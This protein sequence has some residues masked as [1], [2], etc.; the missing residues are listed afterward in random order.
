MYSNISLY[1]LRGLNLD[2]ATIKQIHKSNPG[3][4]WSVDE[5]G[6][7]APLYHGKREKFSLS[8]LIEKLERLEARQSSA[9][10]ETAHTSKYNIINCTLCLFIKRGICF[11]PDGLVHTCTINMPDSQVQLSEDTLTHTKLASHTTDMAVERGSMDVAAV[12][13]TPVSEQQKSCSTPE[14]EAMSTSDG[15]SKEGIEQRPLNRELTRTI[16]VQTLTSDEELKTLMIVEQSIAPR[17]MNVG[18]IPDEALLQN[19]LGVNVRHTQRCSRS[20]IG[21]ITRVNYSFH[22]VKGTP[23]HVLIYAPPGYGKTTLQKEMFKKGIT[24]LDTD[25]IPDP[26]PQDIDELLE[27]TSV[28]TN[29]WQ[30]VTS[31][32]PAIIFKPACIKTF[33]RRVSDKC[34]VTS[35]V[36][37]QW[38]RDIRDRMH[39]PKSAIICITKTSYVTDWFADAQFRSAHDQHK[40]NKP[41]HS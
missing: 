33:V 7:L 41:L 1:K 5:V 25:R 24:L 32:T 34:K 28:L 2:L 40:K 30:L 9:I 19:T 11:L 38:Y 35:D 10:P 17:R 3:R 20:A 22:G 23:S 6:V 13:E 12:R 31:R 14:H 27:H 15:K 4:V 21:N 36:A 29:K 37:A 16:P 18:R 39:T 8:M 26:S